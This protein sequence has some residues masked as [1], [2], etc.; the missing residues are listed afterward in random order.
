MRAQLWAAVDDEICMNDC[1]IYRWV[2]CFC[3][4]I[5]QTVKD[6]HKMWRSWYVSSQKLLNRLVKCVGISIY[7]TK[8]KWSTSHIPFSQKWH[9]KKKLVHDNRTL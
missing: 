2:Y 5:A 3:G 6:E 9:L 4:S 7:I 1:D 8:F